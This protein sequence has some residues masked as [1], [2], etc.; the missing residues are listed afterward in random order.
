LGG[1]KVMVLASCYQSEQALCG[2]LRRWGA[3]VE[4]YQ[5]IDG[6]IKALR[7]AREAPDLLVL[8]VES[9]MDASLPSAKLLNRVRTAF[10]GPLVLVD[11]PGGEVGSALLSRYAPACRYVKPLIGY[12]FLDQIQ[13]LRQGNAIVTEKRAS[14]AGLLLRGMKI[15]IAEDNDF[16]RLLIEK[17]VT[18]L[19]AEAVTA[20]QGFEVV[21]RAAQQ[22]FDAILMDVHMP[23]MDG[24][25]A[26]RKIRNSPGPCMNTPIIALTA[27]V[28]MDEK[29]ALAEAG[30]QRTLFKPIDEGVLIQALLESTAPNDRPPLLEIGPAGER[31]DLSKYGMTFEELHKEL[32]FQIDS[33]LGG[34]VEN[35]IPVM[36]NHS[37][38]LL[39]LASLL[40]LEHLEAA[41]AAFNLSVKRGGWRDIWYHLWRLKRI[42]SK[43]DAL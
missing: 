5:R 43:F 25:E 35:S 12:Q 4:S 17:M 3:R 10:Q 34:F 41:T 7:D 8:A 27:D 30:V 31:Y 33:I 37:H 6:V 20:R 21:D 11:D 22:P 42:V 2:H 18:L 39:G 1:V 24:I 29:L 15:L 9:N 28:M 14:E 38:Q 32:L 36:R 13:A 26:A 40:S 19:G 23:A 16:N